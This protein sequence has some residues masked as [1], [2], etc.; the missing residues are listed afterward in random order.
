LLG[1]WHRINVA[2]TRAKVGSINALTILVFPVIAVN[3]D[4]FCALLE[5]KLLHYG[6]REKGEKKKE[7]RNNDEE[8][9][10][11]QLS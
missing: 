4:L 1:D 11:H 7:K 6:E 10:K 3:L 8:H 5:K 9:S 2:L